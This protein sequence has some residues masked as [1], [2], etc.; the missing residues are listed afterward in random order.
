MI[1][2]IEEE[3]FSLMSLRYNVGLAR[4]LVSKYPHAAGVQHFE[5]PVAD[6]STLLGFIQIDVAHALTVDIDKPGIVVFE[7]RLKGGLLIDGWH[8]LY[9]RKRRGLPTMNVDYIMNP[10]LLAQIQIL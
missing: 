2:Q 7:R 8:R 1:D 4:R 10:E 5:V 9:E 3:T 6:L